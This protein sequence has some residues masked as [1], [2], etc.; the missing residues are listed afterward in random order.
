[1]YLIHERYEYYSLTKGKIFT[2]WFRQ[3]GEYSTEKEAQDHINKCVKKMNNC[4]HEY[5][6]IKQ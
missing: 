6:I 3:L 4:L 2:Q 5:K 1:M